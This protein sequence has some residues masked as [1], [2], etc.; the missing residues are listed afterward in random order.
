MDNQSGTAGNSN[1]SLFLETGFFIFSFLQEL[2]TPSAA[3]NQHQQ[4]WKTPNPFP[5]TAKNAA[6][7]HTN[8]K[9]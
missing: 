9:R 6:N 2:G 4:C 7:K 3:K 8:K 5:F 1:S